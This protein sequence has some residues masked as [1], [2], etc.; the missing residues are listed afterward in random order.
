MSRSA[1][2]PSQDP[3]KVRRVAGLET[4]YGCL[5]CN[6]HK[7]HEILPEIRDWI[8]R[9]NRYGL[10]DL[11]HRDWDEPP[12]NGGFLFNGGRLYIDMGHLEYCTPECLTARDLVL[13]DRVGD[14]I[15]NK[16]VEDLGLKGEITFIRN[17]IDH[18]TGATFGCHENYSM[19]RYAPITEESVNSLLAFLTL[20]VVMIGAG[21]VASARVRQQIGHDPRRTIGFQLSQRADFIQN[22]IYEWV[23]QNRAIINTRDEPLADPNNFRRL[24]LLHGDTNVAPASLFL[25]G[26]TTRLVLDLLEINAL[27]AIELDH[28][29][30]ALRWLSRATEPPWDVE[31]ANGS[32]AD[33]LE[34]LEQYRQ[35]CLKEFGD[36]DQETKVLLQLW[37]RTLKSLAG[38]RT[39]LI[40]L[41]D[42]V[43][44]H[45]LLDNFRQQEDLDWS[46]SWLESQDLQYHSI[47]PENS[48]GLA[49]ADDS[50]AWDTTSAGAML[51]TA[52]T[53]TR[54]HARSMLMQRIVENGGAYVINWDRIEG[55]GIPHHE[56]R[57]P[58]ATNIPE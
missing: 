51:T 37:E 42:W 38:D 50:S 14:I 8:F 13:H 5:S 55:A 6:N 33:V 53:D 1:K 56:M 22:D 39:D 29:T 30:A 12:G 32:S 27:P 4:E 10:L 45:Y 16:A 52:P 15:I 44:K 43:T 46:D 20:R 24:H 25:K 49:I 17:N 34:L 7:L 36:R 11:H 9:D 35:A 19:D 3:A 2:R 31:L 28:A 48:L 21:C 47:D 54:A 18:Y 57:N 58:F 40:G 26:G 23:Q 41:V